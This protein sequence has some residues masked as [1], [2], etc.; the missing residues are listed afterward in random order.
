MSRMYRIGEAAR[1]LN[2]KTYVLRFWETEF[3]QLTPERSD[4]GQRLYTEEHIELLRRIQDLLHEQGMTIEGAKKYL[5]SEPVP[6]APTPGQAAGQAAG[7]APGQAMG[8]A[9]AESAAAPGPDH[10]DLLRDLLGELK[11][12]RSM[13]IAP[14]IDSP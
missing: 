2:L 11:D 6:A 3:P 8:D 9:L 1:L 13:L 14:D 12:I 4:K 10:S 5:A 7:Q